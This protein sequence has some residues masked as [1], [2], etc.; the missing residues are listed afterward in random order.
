MRYGVYIGR[1]QPFH[2]GHEETL[3]KAL[4]EFDGVIVV[5]G[6]HGGPRTTKNPFTTHERIRMI[7]AAMEG[8]V[9]DNRLVYVTL[10]DTPYDNNAW[11]TDVLC[12]IDHLTRNHSVMLV[13]HRKDRSSFYIDLLEM[14]GLSFFDLGETN[15]IINATD[16]RRSLLGSK[17]GESTYWL[18][19]VQ[20]EVA[21]IINQINERGHLDDLRTD[22][23]AIDRFQA[24]YADLKYKPIFS[25]VDA[26]VTYGKSILLIKRGQHPGKGLYALP[27]GFLE[28]HESIIDGM[29]REL[30]EET[31][32]FLA[33]E[34]I[35]ASK[36]F[37]YPDRDLRG[38]FITSAFH[39]K[40][41]DGSRVPYL[42]AGDD[43]DS[44]CWKSYLECMNDSE[45]FYADH[46][47]IIRYFF[48]KEAA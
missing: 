21:K 35:V 13:G 5:L 34:E 1:F 24:P 31:G 15:P 23:E 46:L 40:I 12:K 48:S 41:P 30:A 22:L 39:V 44:A 33:N 7:N 14:A 6:S 29:K 3:R 37:D 4:L 25:T 42:R 9:C 26:V 11:V 47:E 17:R 10:R 20:P 18:E 43:A 27:G 45:H 8:G 38:R 2:K 36:V 32:L 19:Y 16:I 28:A